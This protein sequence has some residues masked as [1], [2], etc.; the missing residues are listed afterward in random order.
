MLYSI[1]KVKELPEKAALELTGDDI[2]IIEDEHDTCQIKLSEL[3]TY[4]KHDL[5]DKDSFNKLMEESLADILTRLDKA[6]S[7][8]PFKI[9]SIIK[10][11]PVNLPGKPQDTSDKYIE[12]QNNIE[13]E[14]NKKSIYDYEL[15]IT[16]T[17]ELNSYY[18]GGSILDE[19]QWYGIIV[20]FNIGNE[21]VTY[22]ETQS[23][24]NWAEMYSI[25][26]SEKTDVYI[27]NGI[28]I[29]TATSEELDKT[30][31]SII[32]WLR[33]DD[34]VQTFCFKDNKD[35]IIKLNISVNKYVPEEI[36]TPVIDQQTYAVYQWNQTV[37]L[38]PIVSI[39]NNI[40]YMDFNGP[41]PYSSQMVDEVYTSG[42][43]IGITIT[44]PISFSTSDEQYPKVY[45]DGELALEGWKNFFEQDEDGNVIVEDISK[46][47]WNL[48]FTE[49]KRN[50]LCTIDWGI[51]Y[52]DTVVVNAENATLLYP[53]IYNL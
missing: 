31:N 1:K 50:I 8:Y 30:F 37:G 24:G 5:I 15:I 40:L 45:Y 28:D 32:V 38:E 21:H 33:A 20:E 44:P 23:L 35:N 3:S 51:G 26:N 41:I 19:H 42:H 10:T 16:E 7:I 6:E 13:I 29:N 2:L 53:P 43:W 4:I 14:F 11:L 34:D 47:N 36:E 27:F 17:A 52:I 22:D 12:N 39:K 18:S 46:A 49:L 48:M 25:D 9:N